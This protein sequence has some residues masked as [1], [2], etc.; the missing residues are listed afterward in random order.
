M[1]RRDEDYVG[2]IREAIA[3]AAEYTAWYDYDR[4]LADRK[5]QDAVVR[6]LEIIGEAAKQVSPE[7][8][9]QHS[10]IPWSDLA[11]VRDKLIHHYFGVDFEIVWRITREELPD[12]AA[13]LDQLPPPSLPNSAP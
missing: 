3:R 5:T 4:F 9:E 12:V 13:K 2:D 6:N 7:F 11:R 8:R 10:Q 1:S